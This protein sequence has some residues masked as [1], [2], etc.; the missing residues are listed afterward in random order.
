MTSC[1]YEAWRRAYESNYQGML[2]VGCSWNLDGF[3]SSSLLIM[4]LTQLPLPIARLTWYAGPDA[5]YQLNTLSDGD[6]V[7]AIS[8]TSSITVI[9]RSVPFSLKCTRNRLAA[10]LRPEPLGELERSTRPSSRI[11]G[12]YG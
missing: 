1:I 10:G 9:T 5:E 3:R 6:A 4:K 11:K 12:W 7:D 8:G 2:Q